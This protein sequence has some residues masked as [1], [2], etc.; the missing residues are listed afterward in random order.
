MAAELMQ[1]KVVAIV[2]Q[3]TATTDRQVG[4]LEHSGRIRF[5]RRSDRS[6]VGRKS[7]ST[8]NEYDRHEL[9]VPGAS[10]KTSGAVERNSAKSFEDRSRFHPHTSRRKKRAS[11]DSIGGPDFKKL[12][13]SIYQSR[14]PTTSMEHSTKSLKGTLTPC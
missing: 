14:Q 1:L 4:Y 10:G 9:S 12:V 11:R 8:G 2:T 5:Q 3:G 7:G 6:R 13:F